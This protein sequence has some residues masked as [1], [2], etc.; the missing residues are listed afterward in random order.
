MTTSGHLALFRLVGLSKQKIIEPSLTDFTG[1]P[2]AIVFTCTFL[3]CI[4]SHSKSKSLTG[5][6][7]THGKS[8]SLAA[9]VNCSRQEQMHSWQ[10]QINSE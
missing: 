3:E 7:L 8:N 2:F 10:K 4:N 6:E 1:S 9:K 5:K